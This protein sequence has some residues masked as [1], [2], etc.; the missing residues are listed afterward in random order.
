MTLSVWTWPTPSWCLLSQKSV[1]CWRSVWSGRETLNPGTLSG[2]TLRRRSGPGTQNLPNLCWKSVGFVWNLE[3]HRKS[4]PSV[5]KTL[6]KL[7]FLQGNRYLLWNVVMAGKWNQEN[8]CPCNNS[9]LPTTN[10]P[11]PWGP[12]MAKWGAL[13]SLYLSTFRRRMIDQ[14]TVRG[15]WC[16]RLWAAP[17]WFPLV[18]GNED[19]E[20]CPALEGKRGA[21]WKLEQS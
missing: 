12:N 5:P 20:V 16:L 7:K 10:A 13:P 6:Q 9:A 1:T 17:R 19:S 4:L 2:R 11:S 21:G 14:R 15:S 18:S 8:G 3:K